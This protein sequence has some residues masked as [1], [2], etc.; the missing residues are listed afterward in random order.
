MEAEIM[1]AIL[2]AIRSRLAFRGLS[3]AEERTMGEALTFIAEDLARFGLRT[4]LSLDTFQD[5]DRYLDMQCENGRPNPGTLLSRNGNIALFALGL[6]AGE[7]IRRSRDGRWYVSRTRPGDIFKLELRLDN[8][9]RMWPVQRVLKRICNGSEDSLFSY[10]Q[11]AVTMEAAAR[12]NGRSGTLTKS[13]E[14]RHR[15][16]S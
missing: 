2:S 4:D 15:W 16:R 5:L 13:S 12:R 14:G 6:Y 10:G 8:D 9:V 3:A 11:V 1:K 7:A